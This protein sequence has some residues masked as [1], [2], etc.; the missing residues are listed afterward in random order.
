MSRCFLFNQLLSKI[1]KI[2]YFNLR[3]NINNSNLSGFAN[4]DLVKKIAQHILE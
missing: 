1:N 4:V 3:F 2:N